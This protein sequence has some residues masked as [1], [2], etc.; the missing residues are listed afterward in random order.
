MV[1]KS[2][3]FAPTGENAAA[4]AAV[5]L[6]AADAINDGEMVRPAGQPGRGARTGSVLCSTWFTGMDSAPYQN[7]TGRKRP[8][9]VRLI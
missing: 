6:V 4:G 5:R 2:L 7:T 9:S 8:P 3:G 1:F